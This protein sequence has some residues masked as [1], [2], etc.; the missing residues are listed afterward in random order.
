MNVKFTRSGGSC[1]I[2]ADEVQLMLLWD[3][4]SVLDVHRQHII[5]V[6]ID[7]FVEDVDCKLFSNRQHWIFLCYSPIICVA[8]GS[9][10]HAAK[11]ETKTSSSKISPAH[12]YHSRQ[13]N[14]TETYQRW[15]LL[16]HQ[17][18]ETWFLI[19]PTWYPT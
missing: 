12:L 18:E 11:G 1:Q 6:D 13:T 8:F 17:G 10:V 19:R 16:G 4:Y 15:P 5:F 14:M 7:K 3:S 2:F 9:V